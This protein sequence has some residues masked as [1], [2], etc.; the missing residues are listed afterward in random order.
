MNIFLRLSLLSVLILSTF[1]TFAQ[2]D[3]FLNS[4]FQSALSKRTELVQQ[5]AFV[6]A[7][8]LRVQIKIDTLLKQ[9][10]TSKYLVELSDSIE[11][12]Q[13]IFPL[14]KAE[15]VISLNANILSRKVTLQARA[16]TATPIF[17]TGGLSHIFGG[18]SGTGLLLDEY[19]QI[20]PLETIVL[21][22]AVFRIVGVSLDKGNII[23]QVTT[24]DYP[25]TTEAGHFI[26]ARFVDTFWMP[27][28]NLESI[29]RT[30]PSQETILSKLR[31]SLGLP[32][33]WG[34][35]IPAGIPKL[36]QYYPPK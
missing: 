1:Q 34:G 2:T 25:Y 24:P 9:G 23:Y 20:D 12:T 17:Y 4:I 28:T 30:M 8:S 14:P 5:E 19:N 11:H 7:V 36:L 13:V 16:N 31:D 21:S 6:K 10:K 26:D 22:G 3:S 18:E 32:Y 15:D 27:L 29:K 35:N 33:I